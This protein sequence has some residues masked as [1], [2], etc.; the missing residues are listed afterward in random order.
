MALR[1]PQT[2]PEHQLLRC[3]KIKQNAKYSIGV[4]F[5]ALCSPLPVTKVP[6]FVFLRKRYWWI[7]PTKR[8]P[9]TSIFSRGKKHLMKRSRQARIGL[10]SFVG[11]YAFD[12]RHKLALQ[13][14]V[15]HRGIGPQQSQAESAINEQQAVNL[16]RLAIA[17]KK[18]LHW[19]IER[20]GDL[21]QARSTNAV[22]A[23]LVFLH[24]WN[25]TP[26]SSASSVWEIFISTRRSRMRLP[27]SRSYLP[28]ERVFL[29]PSFEFFLPALRVLNV[30][31]F[32]MVLASPLP[33]V[34][35]D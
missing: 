29:R 32:T 27:S 2:R 18:K 7:A 28:V 13:S 21:L 26:T 15:L 16:T 24:C 4:Y 31:F 8:Q 34:C 22:D 17:S 1:D 33:F 5:P 35:P 9:A 25:V 20:R 14:L 19:H 23:F 6:I 10:E 30:V 11:S 12:K 3:S